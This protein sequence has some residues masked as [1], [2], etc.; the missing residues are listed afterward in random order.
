MEDKYPKAAIGRACE[1]AAVAWRNG[2][3]KDG[4]RVP[5]KREENLVAESRPSAMSVV[6]LPTCVRPLRTAKDRSIYSCGIIEFARQE[7]S[8]HEQASRLLQADRAR[9]SGPD[10]DSARKV[11]GG[12][13]SALPPHVAFQH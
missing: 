12:D 13:V 2:E 5:G 10:E 8:M 1:Q 7:A 11:G 4:S 9:G 3:G 6:T